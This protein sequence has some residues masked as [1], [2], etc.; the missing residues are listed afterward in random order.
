MNDTNKAFS[1][2]PDLSES[3]IDKLLNNNSIN[4][5]FILYALK[6][7]FIRKI[8]LYLKDFCNSGDIDYSYTH[9]E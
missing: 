1:K 8:S 4:G 5:H 9:K 7:A 6:E 2:Y 3:M